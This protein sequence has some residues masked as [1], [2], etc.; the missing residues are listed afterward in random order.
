MPGEIPL[1]LQTAYA[2]LLDRCGSA[3]FSE[4]FPEDGTFTPKIVRGNRYWYFQVP[5]E[6]GRKQRYVGPETPE[7]LERIAHHKE[8][9]DD[10]RDR[11]A[12]VSAL[13]RSTNLPR[14]LPQIGDVVAVLARGGVFRLRG[15]LVG[16][17]AYQTYS[18]MLGV[19]LPASTIQTGDVDIAQFKNI[20][21]AVEDST[22]T[23]IELLRQVDPSFRPVPHISDGRRATS[24]EGKAGVRVDFLTPNKGRD[25]DVPEPLRAFGT[26]A[27]PLRFLDFLIHDP[28]PAVVL[29]GPG[30]YV[31]VP[32]PQRYAVHKLIIS[33]RRREG[34]AKKDKDI[35]QA[36][37]LLA[38][39]TGKRPHELRDAWGEAAGRGE[40]WRRSLVRGLSQLDPQVRDATL[41][42]IG[43]ARSTIPGLD[44]RF[45][46]SPARYDSARDVVI[47]AGKAADAEVRCEI[48]R[49][50][51][52]DHF[53]ADG[54]DKDG[55]IRKFR[56]NR[57]V[58]ERM[59]R[60]KY[61][62]WPVDEINAVLI[63]TSDVAKL[64]NENAPSS[65]PS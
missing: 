44:L 36:E 63:K 15:V 6:S 31:L 41:R 40:T 65:L 12:L 35:Q 24:Y 14:P 37:A 17:V 1:S 64:L 61:L 11:R 48:S 47:F 9:R 49:A 58:I 20:S 5:T 18:A 3:A 43:E 45:A 21:V 29:H 57:A 4:A 52:D 46:D 32:V 23:A 62:S 42:T 13:V 2:D 10:E 30:V 27:Q 19:R 28:E 53:G 22:P 38:V 8:A 59:A 51:L 56:E 33:Q 55:R 7:L 60:V 16:T 50:A 26:D 39:L 25:S 34:A 54:L